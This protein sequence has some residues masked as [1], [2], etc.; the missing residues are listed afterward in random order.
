MECLIQHVDD[1]ERRVIQLAG[2]LGYDQVPDLLVVCSQADGLKVVLDLGDLLTADS[3]G[4]RALR[5]LRGDG[6]TFVNMS[7]Y[8]RIKLDLT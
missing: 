6:A 2:R 7:E 5:R 4:V 8:I 1:G 3:A